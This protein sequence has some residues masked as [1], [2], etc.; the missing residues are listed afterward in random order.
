MPSLDALHSACILPPS[1]SDQ[2]T[3][4]KI[5]LSKVVQTRPERGAEI[6]CCICVELDLS[7]KVFVYGK[8]VSTQ[9]C[10]L[11]HGFGDKMNSSSFR[12]LLKVVDNSNICEGNYED[13]FVSLVESRK[14]SIKATNGTVSAYLDESVPAYGA[15][16]SVCTKTVRSS[17]CELMT[18]QDKCSNCIAYRKNLRALHARNQKESIQSKHERVEASSHTNYRYLSSPEKKARMTNLHTKTKVLTQQVDQLRKTIKDLTAL[19]GINLE[20]TIDA[21]IR[22]IIEE[23]DAAVNQAYSKESFE[24]LFWKQQKESMLLNNAKQMRWHPMLIKWCIHLR[25]LSS[26]CYNSLMSTGVL[27]L[28]SERTLRDYTNFIKA[29]SGFQCE[30]DEQLFKEAKIEELADHQKYIALIFDEVKI[31]EDLVYNKHTGEMIGFVNVTNINQH[32]TTFEQHCKSGINPETPHHNLATHMLVFMV[33]G[34]FSTLEFP[35]VQ[36]PV[37]S[38][39]GDILHSLVWQCIEH[40]EI[41]GLKVIAVVCDGATP[42]RK[43]FKMHGSSK[44]LTYKATNIYDNSRPV[45]FISDVPHLLKTT[46]NSWANSYAHKNSRKLWVCHQLYI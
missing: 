10:S 13:H 3:G 18:D 45:F 5:T 43:F 33:R 8:E 39:T 28:P 11:M 15:N 36:F 41:I 42:N 30:V 16:G 7:W 2:S 19:N 35:Y 34:L 44:G 9:S 4:N 22:G 40:L 27:R 21:D 32:L 24:C 6:V 23:N 37:A 17:H 29:K 46:R 20:P 1:W 14:G 12:D 38:S 31:K 26:S 25:M